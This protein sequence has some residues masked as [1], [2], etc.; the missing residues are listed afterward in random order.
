MNNSTLLRR[1]GLVAIGISLGIA[2]TLGFESFQTAT[3]EPT[4]ESQQ[5]ERRQ[6]QFDLLLKGE[7]SIGLL[8]APLTVVE[9]SDYQCPYCRRFQLDVFP[10]LKKEFIDRG[11]VRF[12]HKDLPLPFHPQAE[13]SAA[14]TRCALRQ[15]R[16]WSIQ[17][18]LYKAENCLACKGP[19]MI[20]VE[21]G[22]DKQQ[23]KRCLEDPSIENAVRSNRS[24]AELHGIS[25]TPTFIV[26]ATLGP[27]THRGLIVEGALPWPSFRALIE[28][29]L[30]LIGETQK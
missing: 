17:Q 2:G 12:V 26:G 18:A 5:N 24:E 3:P 22:L 9:F 21:A 19:V 10:Q 29:E 23:L 8:D 30:H 20:G 1:F 25:S 13:A 4:E 7:P 16:F 27:D 11:L 14:V 28:N 6:L 15:N